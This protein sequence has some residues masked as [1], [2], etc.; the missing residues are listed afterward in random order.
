[1]A[2]IEEVTEQNERSIQEE[3]STKTSSVSATS[4]GSST[5]NPKE[6]LMT[7]LDATAKHPSLKVSNSDYKVKWG[8]TEKLIVMEIHIGGLSYNQVK[9]SY[10]DKSFSLTV[11]DPQYTLELQ[12]ANPIVKNFCMYKCLPDYFEV[13]LKKDLARTSKRNMT[14][15]SLSK[16]G[17]TTETS[18]RKEEAKTTTESIKEGAKMETNEKVSTNGQMPTPKITHD[19]YQTDTQVIVEVRIKGLNPE[20]VKVEFGPTSLS[21]TAK[22][23]VSSAANGSEYSLEL[24]LANEVLPQECVYK[25]LST[26]LEMKMKKKEGMR[27]SALE[28]DGSLDSLNKVSIATSNQPKA[29]EDDNSKN[30]VKRKGAKDWD[31]INKFLDTELEYLKDNQ[32]AGDVFSML[33]GDADEAT[34]RAMNKSMQESGGTVL[35]TDWKDIGSRKVERYKDKDE[36]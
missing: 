13:K 11:K 21:C 36:E 8:Q 12:V 22:L 9:V 1:M 26:K 16:D 18:I 24:D 27:W 19:W 20:K 25:V 10:D 28:G 30:P 2:V 5:K 35:S 17:T 6:I 4:I 14:W 31:K 23:P 33:Y 32:D 3:M 7:N 15:A 29:N 34:K